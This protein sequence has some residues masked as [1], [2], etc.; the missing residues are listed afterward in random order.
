VP[1][2]GRRL[3][4]CPPVVSALYEQRRDLSSPRTSRSARSSAR[5]SERPVGAPFYE[6]SV[7][8]ALKTNAL[9][10]VNRRMCRDFF[11]RRSRTYPAW[12][13]Q[14]SPV[15][16]P[17]SLVIETRGAWSVVQQ[18]APFFGL[19][20]MRAAV[21]AGTSPTFD[22]LLAESAKARLARSHDS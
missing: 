18:F 2:W 13:C 7:A 11:E 5:W 15:L 1:A 3:P 4:T 6:I 10:C 22:A 16:K 17:C 12:G 21:G 20:P 8:T 19:A 14:T 9:I